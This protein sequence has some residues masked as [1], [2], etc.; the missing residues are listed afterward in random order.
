MD[1]RHFRQLLD[2]FG[3]S[4]SG[5][6]R[7]RKG[8][9]KRIT[10]HMQEI[11]CRTVEAYLQ[12][13]DG[14][15]TLRH[16]HQRLM[17][18]SISCFFRDRRLW[19]VMKKQILPDLLRENTDK[20]K[21][22]SAGCAC[23]E[24]VY[25]FQMVWEMLRARFRNMPELEIWATDINRDYLRRAQGGKY[26]LSSLKAVPEDLRTKYFR[27]CGKEGLY[28]IAGSLKKGILWKVH[29]LLCQ[30]WE[31][32]FQVIF[33]RNNVL[34]YYEAKLKKSAFRRVMD[35]LADGGFL[36]IGSH[37]NLPFESMDLVCFGSQRYIFKRTI[38]TRGDA[39][40]L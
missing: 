16:Q 21:V 1:D 31:H 36:I 28:E 30:P 3:Y 34:T 7:V 23:G 9:K 2:H 5:Y 33:L 40:T 15:K 20:V 32:N 22:W 18:V 13:L 11:G 8:V 35:K 4:W 17:S 12:V 14:N 6:R 24:E 25:S 38:T 10:R 37:E 26:T 27:S 39:A 29:D 19:E